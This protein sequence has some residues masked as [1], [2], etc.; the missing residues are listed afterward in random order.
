MTPVGSRII[1]PTVLGYLRFPADALLSSVVSVGTLHL[2]HGNNGALSVRGRLVLY[3][4]FSL[5]LTLVFLLAR[6]W[7]VNRRCKQGL[8]DTD[9]FL[10][11]DLKARIEMI[12]EM[13]KAEMTG[14]NFPPR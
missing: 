5:F 2:L 4:A 8:L 13:L 3:A 10:A 6:L 9:R 1:L 7:E 14:S 11:S 12:S